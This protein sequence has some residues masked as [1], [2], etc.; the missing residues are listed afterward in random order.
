MA[1]ISIQNPLCIRD[2]AIL[3]FLL[4]VTAV[5]F[6]IECLNEADTSY[7]IV[8]KCRCAELYLIR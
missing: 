2:K 6:I 1:N 5:K 7:D 3:Y 8:T 4:I